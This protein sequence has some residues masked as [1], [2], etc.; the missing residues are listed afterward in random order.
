MADNERGFGLFGPGC[1]IIWIIIAI[2]IILPLFGCG[3][4]GGFGFRE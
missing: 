2:V 1:E 4:F 3:G